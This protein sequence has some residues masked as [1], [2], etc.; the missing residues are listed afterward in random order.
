MLILLQM[1]DLLVIAIIYNVCLL[2]HSI[3]TNVKYH[4]E[5]LDKHMENVTHFGPETVCKF[6]ACFI[7]SVKSIC[8]F[9]TI[10]FIER[11]ELLLN[12]KKTS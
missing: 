1:N 9:C 12:K 8:Y 3:V 11:K 10:L 7:I 6:E 4:I 5:H 2:L